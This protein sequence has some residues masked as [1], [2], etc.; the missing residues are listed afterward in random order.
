MHAHQSRHIHAHH[1][2]LHDSIVLPSNDKN[3]VSHA[4][5]SS[6]SI[7][8]N[9]CI[10]KKNVDCLGSTLS[11]CAMNHKRLESM[12][13]KKHTPHMHAHPPWHTHAHHTHTRDSMYTSVYTSTH[14]GRKGHLAKFCYDRLNISNFA[15]KFV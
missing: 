13:R 11:Q 6:L 9:I 3:L 4:S 14:C 2:H 12:F 5:S 10:L 8:N 1:T 7:K 15:N